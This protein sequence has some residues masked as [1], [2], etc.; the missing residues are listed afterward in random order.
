M[1]GEQRERRAA[2][3]R[4]RTTSAGAPAT[5]G[6]T[7]TGRSAV[8]FIVR[9]MSRSS[10]WLIAPAPPADSAPPRQVSATSPSDGSPATYIVGDRGEE[11]ERL[12]LRLRHLEVVGDDGA[13]RHAGAR[14]ATSSIRRPPPR[15]AR[16]A[17]SRRRAPA[18]ASGRAS[19][20]HSSVPSARCSTIRSSYSSSH[21]F[22]APTRIWSSE[23]R[24]RSAPARQ[25]VATPRRSATTT[26]R[27][28]EERGEV[29][30]RAVGEVDVHEPRL[31]ERH[32]LAV[33][34]GEL[35]AA[36]VVGAVAELVVGAAVV[37]R[38]GHVAAG[39]DRA[40]HRHRR[41]DRE[42]RGCRGPPSVTGRARSRPRYS[43][44][45]PPSRSIAR[46]R[47]AATSASS[48]LLLDGRAAERR[49]APAIST[50]SRDRRHAGT[51]GGG[52]RPGRRWTRSGCVTIP[53]TRAVG[54]LDDR[55][56]VDAG[57]HV[58]VA[59][60]PAVEAASRRGRSR[61]RSRT[62]ARPRPR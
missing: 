32:E 27:D 1:S 21:T 16:G 20:A 12:H 42:Q 29:H 9:S 4:C 53:A 25:R 54:V 58:A 52:A 14:A 13:V 10:T 57:H 6:P 48:R 61:A 18:G 15:R 35:L 33:A 17:R 22:S 62:R 55:V 23:Q 19:S 2:R 5:R 43:Q 51:R 44:I 38:A 31:A 45:R 8:R 36:G 40:E 26:R 39:D 46:Q 34:G 60:R 50:S 56:E 30:E 24:R 11:Q 7:A 49:L 59:E 41:G 47:C 37:L 28:H 3:A